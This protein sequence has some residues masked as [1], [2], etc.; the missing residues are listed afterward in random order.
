VVGGV[1]LELCFQVFIVLSPAD[2]VGACRVHEG[3][4]GG[5]GIDDL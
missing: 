3:A 1:L 4:W 5:C 2:E